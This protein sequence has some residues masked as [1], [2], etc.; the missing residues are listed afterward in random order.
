MSVLLEIEIPCILVFLNLN[1]NRQFV[2][3]NASCRSGGF[4]TPSC[5]ACAI[6]QISSANGGLVSLI[7]LAIN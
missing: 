3:K 7:T 5:P 1:W 4:A 2:P 6:L